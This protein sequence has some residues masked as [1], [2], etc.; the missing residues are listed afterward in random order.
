MP[1]GSLQSQ[2]EML[3][4]MFFTSCSAKNERIRP[5]ML[6]TVV[7]KSVIGMIAEQDTVIS[8]CSHDR[9]PAPASAP[10]VVA[11]R[12]STLNYR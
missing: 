5:A 4:S 3:E 8:D 6:S 11:Y 7:Q 12:N 9:R 10:N 1:I 2:A